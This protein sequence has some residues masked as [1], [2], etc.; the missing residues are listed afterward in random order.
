MY[1][2][3]LKINDSYNDLVLYVPPSGHVAA[4]YAKTDYVAQ[5][6]FAPA[7]LNRGVLNVL[8]LRYKYNFGDREFL[9]P[10]QISYM[11][12]FPGQGIAVWEQKTMQAKTSALSFMNVR[13]LL[14]VIEISV[15]KALLY[16]NFEPNDDLLRMQIVGM[17]GEFLEAVKNGRGVQQYLV[18]SDASNNSPSNVGQGILQI[19][20]YI[21]PTLPAERILLNVAITKQGASFQELVARG[22]L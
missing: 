7:G 21:T 1:T 19:D 16:S 12:N 11:R 17:I 9:A 10:A 5:P 13:R 14:D 3:D 2:P 8:G 4:V 20:V 15:S 6:W 22:G 18:V